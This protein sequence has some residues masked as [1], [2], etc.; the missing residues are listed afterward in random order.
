M[1]NNEHLG[2]IFDTNL[3]FEQ[4]ASSTNLSGVT[5]KNRQQ[6]INDLHIGT[7]VKLIR[8]SF[9][10]YDK[11]AIGVYTKYNNEII[12]IGWIPK[13]LAELLAPEIDAG[14]K[15]KGKIK[16]ITGQDQPTQGIVIDIF[17]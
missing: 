13:K 10:E 14:I 7:Q 9:N 4:I 3:D 15:W 5:F 12:Q 11:Y 8:D 1:D 2:N 17:V 16:L 6:I